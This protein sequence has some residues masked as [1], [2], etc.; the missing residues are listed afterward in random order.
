[1]HA[2]AVEPAET[3]HAQKFFLWTRRSGRLRL[4]RARWRDRWRRLKALG[5]GLEQLRVDFRHDHVLAK[6][7]FHAK[8][9][10]VFFFVRGQRS[11]GQSKGDILFEL[12]QRFFA[13]L[14]S[15]LLLDF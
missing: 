14:F 12:E 2:K 5:T 9:D 1:A 6:A 10:E 15:D 3:Q 7:V 11:V 8:T 13:L 4:E